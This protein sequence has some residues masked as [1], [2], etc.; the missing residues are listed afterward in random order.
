MIIAHIDDEEFITKSTQ[1]ALQNFNKSL[2]D[3]RQN[4]ETYGQQ[5]GTEFSKPPEDETKLQSLIWA[6]IAL[7]RGIQANA[8]E[9]KTAASPE[10]FD[11]I[12][13]ELQE[14][15]KKP[16]VIILD[17]KLTNEG[18]ESGLRILDKIRSDKIL[19]TQPVIILTT[20]DDAHWAKISL[21]RQ[22]NAY[23]SKGGG[24][25]EKL[26]DRFLEIVVHWC[27]TTKLPS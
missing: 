18:E 24:M 15:D 3:L 27:G 23:V 21:A 1:K 4:P 22:A 26:I 14:T 2:Q 13:K 16:D 8:I 12:V 25:I 11:D 20:H 7:E 17:L 5:A 6:K 9:L 19:N 10:G